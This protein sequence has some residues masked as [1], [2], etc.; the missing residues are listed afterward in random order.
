M[1]RAKTKK[2]SAPRKSSQ[3]LDKVLFVRADQK[4]LDKLEE[5]RQRRNDKTPGIVISR[6]DVARSI[7]WDGLARADEGESK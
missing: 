5:L 6:A 3:G 1:S 2:T 4:L 7:L